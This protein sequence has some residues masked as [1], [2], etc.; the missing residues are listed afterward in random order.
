MV[1]V[2]DF[3]DYMGYF[4]DPEDAKGS[5]GLL[6]LTRTNPTGTVVPIP[7][8]LIYMASGQS[9][10]QANRDV[11]EINES[12]LF[13]EISVQ[14]R[15]A[16]PSGN[17]DADQVWTTNQ[18]VNFTATNPNPF[19]KGQDAKLY[20]HGIAPLSTEGW[21]F[22]NERLQGSLNVGMAV[23]RQLAGDSTTSDNEFFDILS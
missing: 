20:I 1:S 15:H 14:A 4:R 9:F 11:T 13:V 16:G 21:A 17:I 18:N 23:V 22:S 6:L 2:Q 7:S 10:N 19:S 12:Q 3:R 8:D 5:I